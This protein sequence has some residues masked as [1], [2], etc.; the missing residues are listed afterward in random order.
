MSGNKCVTY[1]TISS[2]TQNAMHANAQGRTPNKNSIN[3]R[4][5]LLLLLLV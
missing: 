1:C 2:V 4:T 5:I 3:Q